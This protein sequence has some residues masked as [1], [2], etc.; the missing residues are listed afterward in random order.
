MTILQT[1][2]ALE[3]LFFNLASIDLCCHRKYSRW[4]TAL[5][6]A[7][8][9]VGLLAFCLAFAED[10]SFRADGRMS[11][12]GLIYMIPLHYLLQG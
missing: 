4:K 7:V 9:S 10:I 2:P 3:L 12:F 5:I 6:L 11:L 8:F 1:L